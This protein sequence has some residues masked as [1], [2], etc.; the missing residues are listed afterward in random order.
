MNS[1]GKNMKSTK[2]KITKMDE[3]DWNIELRTN[4]ISLDNYTSEERRMKQEF[5]EAEKRRD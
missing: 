3:C 2:Y 4:N 5:K 1:Q